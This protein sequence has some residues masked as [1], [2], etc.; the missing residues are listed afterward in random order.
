LAG[1]LMSDILRGIIPVILMVL[2][3]VSYAQ[4]MPADSVLQRELDEMVITATRTERHLSNVTVPTLLVNARSIQMSGNLRLNEVLQE[5]TGLFLTSGTGSTSVGG[6]VFGNGI[7]IQGMAPDYTL[8]MLDGEPL[9]GRQGGIIDLSRFTVSNI[10]KIEVIKGP[11][12]ALYGSEAMGGVVNIITEQRRK[13]YISSG[14]R[15]GS[16]HTTDIY[17]SANLDAKKSTFYLFANFNAS[18]GY[19]LNTGTPEKTID[20]YLNGSAQLKWTYRF[21]DRTRLSWNNRIYQGLQSSYFAINGNEINI[22]G[23]GITTDMNINPVLTHLYNDQ[24]KTILKL[25]TSFYRYEQ[26]LNHIDTEETYYADDFQHI[27]LRA[28]N[29]TEWNWHPNAQLIA[30]GGYNL[31]TVNTSR[32]RTEKEEHLGYAFVQ[33]EWK[34]GAKWILIPG[35]RYDINSAYGNHFSPKLSVQFKFSDRTNLNFSYGSGFKAPD[36]RQLYLYY[37]NPAAQGYRV[38]GASEFSVEEMEKHLL[39]GLIIK[40]LPEAYLI[41]GLKPEVSHGFN[42]GMTHKYKSRDLRMDFNLFYNHINDLINYLPV[43]ITNN[44]TL[45]FSYM[46]VKKAYTGGMEYNISGSFGKGFE[47]SSG[48]QLLLTGDQDVLKK[49]FKN[50]VYG[51]DEPLGAS[52]RMSIWDYSG[53]MGRSMHMLNAKLNYINEKGAYGGSIRAIYRSRWGVLDRDG[54]GFANMKEEYAEGFLMVNMSL[55]KKIFKNLTLQLNINN[56]LNQTDALYVPQN[57]GI[58]FLGSLQWNFLT[59]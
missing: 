25:Y 3:S 50:E 28:E 55:Q 41:T 18:E 13:N 1:K 59:K 15:Y 14:I 43:A 6:G 30:G 2:S 26:K 17:S 54:N 58:H 51:R 49:I 21:N 20:P 40:I 53:L 46:N 33:N 5:Q 57:P 44:N 8:I 52:R 35:V 36:F 45:V 31:Q 37:I 19:D 16:Y 22:S 10:R 7:Q 42:V 4:K 29:Q 23:N 47:W 9:I 48:Y 32:Y 27:Y 11:S 38:Y 56:L 39:D 12:S 24:L 34:P